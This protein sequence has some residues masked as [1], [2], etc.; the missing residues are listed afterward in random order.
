MLQSE[1]TSAMKWSEV[2]VLIYQIQS[3]KQFS[4]LTSIISK[5]C[6]GKIA[7][8]IFDTLKSEI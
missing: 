2:Q 1:V 5:S 8:S 6:Y 7:L 4:G 3:L